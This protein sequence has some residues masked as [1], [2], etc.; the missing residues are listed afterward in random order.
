[1]TQLAALNVKITGDSADLQS[2]L[3]KAEAGVKRVGQSANTA[4]TKT[5]GFTGGLGK[6][7]GVSRQTRAQIQNTSFQLQDI[8]VQLEMGTDASRV[9]AQQLPQLFGGF[10]ALGAVLGVVAGVGIPAV[11]FAFSALGNESVSL[12]EK[13]E[14]LKEALDEY[15]AASDKATMTTAELQ[16]KFGEG[17]AGLKATY[18]LLQNIAA[19]KAQEAIDGVAQSLAELV[20]VAG[21]G[22]SRAALADLFDVNIFIAV[23]KAQREARDRARELTAEFK[24]AQ[25]TLQ[26]SEGDLQ[27]QVNATQRLLDVTRTLAA[28]NGS[29]STEERDLIEL[30]G[31]QLAMMQEHLLTQ[32]GVNNELNNGTTAVD[33]TKAIME[34]LVGQASAFAKSLT[35]ITGSQDVARRRAEKYLNAVTEL[36]VKIGE[37]AT[38]ALI[39]GGVDIVSGVNA[40][41]LAAAELAANL[42]ISLADAMKLKALG[43]DPLSAFGGKGQFVPEDSPSW[44]DQ[45]IA[46]TETDP[47]DAFGGGGR[48]IPEDPSQDPTGTQANPLVAQLDNLQQSLMTQEE[49]QIA[50]FERQQETLTSALE[51]QLLTRQEYN[52]LMEDAEAQHSQ[53]MAGLAVYKYGDTLA[54]T[55]QFLGDMASAMQGGNDKMLRIAKVFGAAEALI[56]SYRAY[57]QVISDPSLP[58]FAKIPAAVSVLGAGLG[59]VNAIK[60]VSSGGGSAGAASN[61]TAGGG[62]AAAPQTSNNVA[63]QLTGG[64]MFSR[65]QVIQLINGINDAVDDGAQIRLV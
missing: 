29:I 18:E 49:A 10:G 9:F 17:A 8:A 22:E 63:I 60:G 25:A 62:A 44:V 4:Q 54:Q 21:A 20:G 42:N 53:R 30:L 50:S 47:L 1:M 37:A 27:A 26:A 40:A 61:A 14:K 31:T 33:N 2:D 48:F 32:Q 59:M 15:S 3:S 43:D 58:W 56:N 64:D 38:D 34:D 41:A 28:E 46:A 13:V 11:A 65:D 57:N 51:Q 12:E 5:K 23:T 24:N 55:G 39:L 16:E 19:Q 7:G 36:E 52:E 45:L 35:E 6:L